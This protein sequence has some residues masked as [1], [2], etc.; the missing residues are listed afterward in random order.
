V[1]NSLRPELERGRTSA[2]RT[3]TFGLATVVMLDYYTGANGFLQAALNDWTVSAIVTLQSGQP[4]TITSGVDRNF[5]GLTTDRPD[6][7]GDPKLS[8]GRPRE[9]QIENWFNVNAFALPAAGADGTAG[10][11]IVEGPGVKNVDLGVF[12]D[13]PLVGRSMLQFRVEATNVLNFVNLSNPGTGQNAAA[14]F[15][16]IRTARDMRRIQLGVR[17][18]F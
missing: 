6:L 5:D 3:H 1:Q 17:V 16:K 9:E 12:R 14:T 13:I 11:S 7:I 10:R 8:S 18:S 2:D 4:L 15:G